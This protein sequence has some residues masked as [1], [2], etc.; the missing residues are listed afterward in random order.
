MNSQ[1]ERPEIGARF[2]LGQLLIS[3]TVLAVAMALIS[4]YWRMANNTVDERTV[5]LLSASPASLLFLVSGLLVIGILAIVFCSI[6]IK[7]RQYLIGGLCVLSLSACLCEV[8][9]IIRTT[10][11]DR[12]PCVFLSRNRLC[13][14]DS[15]KEGDYAKEEAFV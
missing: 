4:Q 5:P 3:V 13:F 1:I 11:L 7:R 14:W 8:D 12:N 2:T 9:P 10:G 15:T 6:L